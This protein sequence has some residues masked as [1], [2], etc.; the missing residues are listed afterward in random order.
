MPV[1]T[2]DRW[3]RTFASATATSGSNTVCRRP[4]HQALVLDDAMIAIAS[5]VALFGEI[6]DTHIDQGQRRSPLEVRAA[7][8]TSVPDSLEEEHIC[9]SQSSQPPPQP[10][11]GVSIIHITATEAAPMI[12]GELATAALN[13]H[14]NRARER[15]FMK[16]TLTVPRRS[17]SGVEQG[18]FQGPN[19]S[20]CHEAQPR[21]HRSC[22]IAGLSKSSGSVSLSKSPGSISL[23]HYP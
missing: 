10:S 19:D 22:S 8:P 14:A 12:Y 7:K 6:Y 15:G 5:K 20:W 23:A 16:T 3:G 11:P 1:R 4:R 17:S 18:M 9:L 21:R 13:N 2:G